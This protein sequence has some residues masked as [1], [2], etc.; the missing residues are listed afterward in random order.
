MSQQR[1]TCQ[2]EPH[3]CL[4]TPAW[5][6]SPVGH[7]RG[8][9]GWRR[10]WAICLLLM[11]GL[12]AQT[13]EARAD[14][15]APGCQGEACVT[16][17]TTL[18][19]VDSQDSALLNGLLSSLSGASVSLSL[20]DY[21]A[22]AG[23]HIQLGG[24]LQQLQAD[25]GAASPEAVLMAEITLGELMEA[26][27]TV[28]ASGGNPAAATALN[29]LRGAL[30]GLTGTIQLGALLVIEVDQGSVGAVQLNLLDLVV[31]VIELFNGE[32]V[33]LTPV[34]V[35]LSGADLGLQGLL[36]QVTIQAQALDAPVIVCG[37]DGAQFHSATLRVALI[38]DLVD[39]S[40]GGSIDLGLGTS[41]QVNVILGQLNLYVQVGQGQGTI[42]LVDALAN[43]VTV[44]ATPGVTDLY[45]GQMDPTLFFS[46]THTISATTDLDYG[47]VASAQIN[48]SLLGIPINLPSLI[49]VEA[50][51]FG[52]VAGG[53]P[54]TLT[55]QGPY[56]ETQEV[57]VTGS[58]SGS[59]AATLLANLDVNVELAGL[60]LGA[61]LD[62]ITDLIGTLVNDL[63]DGVLTPLLD[64]LVDPLLDAMGVGLGKMDVTVLGVA[65]A[66]PD[67]RVEKAH[68]GTWIADETGQYTITVENVGTL[69]T[70]SLITVVDQLPA[71]LSYLSFSG[72]G[73]VLAG[74][75]GSSVSFTHP[76]PL[77]PG[78]TLPTLLLT[79][80]I[81]ST[82][83]DTVTNTVSVSV[84]GDSQ[85]ANNQAHDATTVIDQ[86]LDDDGLTNQEES[87]LGTDPTDPDTDD[88]GTL[89]GQ[90][91]EPLN[92]CVP[93]SQAGPCDQDNDGL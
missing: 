49:D 73:W 53:T 65:Q 82:L 35:T 38:V 84:Q 19:T 41:A 4:N 68:S 58:D 93:N 32:H 37:T 88:D 63:L 11:V 72:S 86:D 39:T 71:G 56:P 24:L 79:V 92:P 44:Q 15:A 80:D 12:L 40:Q 57:A 16:A 62:P 69:A 8:A 67:L 5:D 1:T 2:S 75:A 64:S 50:K 47:V 9:R 14:V 89:D 55:F 36:N 13:R 31:G 26:A 29:Q 76:G 74:Q 22:L 28:A 91:P 70:S 87:T 27:S 7:T 83:N 59:L 52:S 78:Q 77:N 6:P 48:A 90:D 45:L 21:Q 54:S 17:G 61:L 25:L 42:T 85:S 51:T 18:T 23:G 10:L 66:C 3:C 30:G 33:L 60:G 20:G 81:A 34:G 43:A 46:R